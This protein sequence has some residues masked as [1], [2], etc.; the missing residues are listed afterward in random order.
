[1]DKF[2]DAFDL[3]DINHL[4]ISITSTE[5]EAVKIVSQERKAQNSMDSL[6]NATRTLKN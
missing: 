1:M 2:L 3:Q 4:N 5:T 6:L